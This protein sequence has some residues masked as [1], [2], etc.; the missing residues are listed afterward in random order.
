MKTVEEKN[1]NSNFCSGVIYM[2][3]PF[4]SLIT[5]QTQSKMS[6]RRQ[7]IQKHRFWAYTPKE[8]KIGKSESNIPRVFAI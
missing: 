6:E 3:I 2:S 7:R 8:T 1:E 5:R 4:H